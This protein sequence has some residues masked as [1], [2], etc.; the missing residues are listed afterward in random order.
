MT[1]DEIKLK[2]TPILEKHR[3][4]Y[5]GVFGSMARGE[6]KPQSDVDIIVRVKNIPFGIWGMVGLKEEFE[7]VLERKVDLLSE[8]GMSKSFAS[9]IKKDLV[10]VYGKG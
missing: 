6:A 4:E 3:A 5:A 2:I 9:R 7:K 10:T 1:V 8:Q